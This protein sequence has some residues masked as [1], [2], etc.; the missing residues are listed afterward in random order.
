MRSILRRV[1]SDRHDLS[2]LPL[3]CTLSAVRAY[4][5]AGCPVAQNE[6]SEKEWTPYASA[7]RLHA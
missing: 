7:T 5:A 3:Q 4:D 6:K 2:E 1:H